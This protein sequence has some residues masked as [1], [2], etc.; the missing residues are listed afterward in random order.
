MG[1]VS[2]LIDPMENVESQEPNVDVGSRV[3][4]SLLGY[5]LDSEKKSS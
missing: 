1:P 4:K 5:G 2:G 3:G